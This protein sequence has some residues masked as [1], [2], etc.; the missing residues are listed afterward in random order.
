MTRLWGRGAE[1]R[2]KEEGRVVTSEEKIQT[3]QLPSQNQSAYQILSESDN[4]FKTAGDKVRGEGEFR[5]IIQTSNIPFQ[6][7]IYEPNVIRIR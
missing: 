5:K 2:K 4:V 3:S 7:K 1:F 6:K